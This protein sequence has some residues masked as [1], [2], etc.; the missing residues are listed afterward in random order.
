MEKLTNLKIGRVQV[1]LD[2][3]DFSNILLDKRDTGVLIALLNRPQKLN[4]ID[5]KLHDEIIALIHGVSEDRGVRAVVLGGNGRSFTAGGDFTS[6]DWAT[7]DHATQQHELQSTQREAL[8]LINSLLLLE[9]P[10][11]SAVHGYAMGLG[12]NLALLCDVV[13]VGTGTTMAETHVNLGLV[14]GDGGALIWPLLLGVNRA[15]WFLMSGERISGAQL[16]EL[17]LANFLVDDE[18]VLAKAIECAELLAA[19]TPAAV[20]GAKMAVNQF[21]RLASS[22]VM[23]LSIALE[24]ATLLSQDFGQAQA[25][26]AGPRRP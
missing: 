11:V 14:P 19:K 26:F 4:A 18:Q 7:A 15:K 1:V 2:Q 17:G 10:I 16:Y 20:A 3:A 5:Q 6:I 24:G 13:V 8:R 12:A 21:V 25:S 22:L 9:K 23:P